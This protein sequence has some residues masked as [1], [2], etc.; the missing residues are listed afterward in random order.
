[1]RHLQ[2]RISCDIDR[3]PSAHTRTRA[4][5]RRAAPRRRRDGLHRAKARNG[6]RRRRYDRAVPELVDALSDAIDAFVGGVAR[7]L[8]SVGPDPLARPIAQLRA[9]LARDALNMAA[10]VIDCDGAQSD[11]E[12]RTYVAA[13]ADSFPDLA[14]GDIRPE[15]VRT[16]GLVTG[17]RSFL[18][19]P[20]PLFEAI[21]TADRAA[22]T[23]H[24]WV[25]YD[26]AMRV[27]F[28]TVSIDDY[29][30]EAEL[31][32]IERFRTALL[33]ATDRAGVRDTTSTA[34]QSGGAEG[35]RGDTAAGAPAA[36][37]QAAPR[38]LAELMN[39]LDSLVGMQGVKQ[40]VR[41]VT[42]LIQV[43]K[44][45]EERG[46]RTTKASRHLV[47]V[48]NPGTG[49]TT[50]ARILAQIYR[51]LGVVAKGHLV[52]TDRAGLVAGYVGQTATKVQAVF[53][54]A[55]QGVLLID[56]AYSLARGGERD[57]GQEAIDTVVKLV[58]DRRDR[59]VCIMAGYPDEMAQLIESNPGLASRFPKTIVFPDYTTDELVTIFEQAADRAGYTLATE[60]RTTVHAWLDA[61]P[62]GRGF[63]NG[64]EARNLFEAAIARHAARVVTIAAPTNDDLTIVQPADVAGVETGADWRRPF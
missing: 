5:A 34:S 48:G 35:G 17:K 36:A 30:A 59:V 64:R 32:S 8:A 7:S 1:L 57:F 55:D 33:E 23:R 27:L 39:E 58:E 42:A 50:V 26:L 4:K 20:S 52:E 13:L 19:A 16:S 18:E 15:D 25:Y 53:E 47:F 62:R 46:L 11:A 51:T 22:G 21:I 37:A 14:R 54:Q 31:K 10:G 49:K 3:Q 44:L 2:W 40:E 24:W 61:L 56:E 60:T 43:Q 63:G 38:P 41:L 6:Q 28:T 9:D 29:T 12:L 45:R